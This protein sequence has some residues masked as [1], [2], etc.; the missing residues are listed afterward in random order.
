MTRAI[1]WFRVH[2]RA[3]QSCGPVG[4]A[5]IPERA[6]CS[7]PENRYTICWWERSETRL[8]LIEGHGVEG[9][10]ATRQSMRSGVQDTPVADGC[11]NANAWTV[12]DHRD[13]PWARGSPAAFAQNG[14]WSWQ[15]V[16]AH[17][18]SR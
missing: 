18:Q 2:S 11:G 16:A 6:W 13:L 8:G 1:A 12:C 9:G 7:R 17:R 3:G 4:P 14:G 10:V 5:A 15:L